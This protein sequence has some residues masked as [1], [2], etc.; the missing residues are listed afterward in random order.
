MFGRGS[1]VPVESSTLSVQYLNAE[2]NAGILVGG[3]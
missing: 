2:L 1:F 3:K